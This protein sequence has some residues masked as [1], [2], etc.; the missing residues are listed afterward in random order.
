MTARIDKS[1]LKDMREML[2][3]L[4]AIEQGADFTMECTFCQTPFPKDDP[5]YSMDH[6]ARCEKDRK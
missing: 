6:L 3:M 2:E 4:Q 1:I 5:D